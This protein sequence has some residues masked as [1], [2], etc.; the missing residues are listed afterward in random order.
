MDKEIKDVKVPDY[1]E[2]YK[3][4]SIYHLEAERSSIIIKATLDFS[5][6]NKLFSMQER[7]KYIGTS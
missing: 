7:W 1:L 3:K 6:R 4:L 2:E 5:N